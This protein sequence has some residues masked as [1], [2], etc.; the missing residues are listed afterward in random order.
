MLRRDVIS[1]A[2]GKRS[3]LPWGVAIGEIGDNKNTAYFHPLFIY[4]QSVIVR[5]ADVTTESKKKWF[6]KFG[7]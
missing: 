6:N 1:A 5:V 2:H 7:L 3:R 4:N